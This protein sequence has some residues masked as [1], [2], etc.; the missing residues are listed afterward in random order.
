MNTIDY[1]S[2][3]KTYFAKDWQEFLEKLGMLRKVVEGSLTDKTDAQLLSILLNSKDVN[4][5][6]CKDPI[7]AE[8]Y[9]GQ[10]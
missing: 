8:G 2:E 6:K 10:T 5:L 3:E 9:T 7:V 1:S 4:S